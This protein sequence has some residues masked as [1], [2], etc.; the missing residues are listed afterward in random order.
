MCTRSRTDLLVLGPSLPFS[1]PPL[2]S[3]PLPPALLFVPDGCEPSSLPPS[4][5]NG[6]LVKHSTVT[7]P[8]AGRDACLVI[9]TA[10]SRPVLRTC[11]SAV[12]PLVFHLAR[13]WASRVHR[14]ADGLYHIGATPV[15]IN[16]GEKRQSARAAMRLGRSTRSALGGTAACVRAACMCV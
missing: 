9:A 11:L 13:F 10:L 16:A 7:Q 8:L 12:L 6:T 15:R 2:L 5:G 14:G 3:L 1:A 4:N